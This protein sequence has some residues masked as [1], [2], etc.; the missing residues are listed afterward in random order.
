MAETAHSKPWHVLVKIGTET[1]FADGFDTEE[2][3]N[4]SAD[5]KNREAEKMG[6]KS[7]YI[8]QPKG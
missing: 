7:R 2:A 1:G 4:H 5:A 8:V 3:A 6:I